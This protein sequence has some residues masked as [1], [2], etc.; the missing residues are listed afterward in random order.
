M[1]Y[2]ILFLL[3]WCL[4]SCENPSRPNKNTTK[5]DV[6]NMYKGNLGVIRNSIYARHGYSLRSRK[7]RYV[8][9][10][11][12]WYIPISVD[13]RSKLTPLEKKNIDLLK[14]YEQHANTYYDSFGR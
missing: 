10:Q 1:K 9:D 12:E 13:I 14:R 6:E 8:L 11:I 4:F 5:E 3:L 7:M 2:A